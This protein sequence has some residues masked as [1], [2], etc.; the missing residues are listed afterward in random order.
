MVEQWKEFTPFNGTL[1]AFK[2]YEKDL[3]SYAS[4][5]TDDS[6]SNLAQT[7]EDTDMG[8]AGPGAAPMP[9]PAAPVGGGGIAAAL[10]LDL[11]KMQ[12]LRT[13]RLAAAYQLLYKSNAD[14]DLKSELHST[15]RLPAFPSGALTM[16]RAR[17]D[18]TP[19]AA[20]MTE[21]DLHWEG[22]T[23]AKDVGFAAD[24]VT[25][26]ASLLDRENADRPA[27]ARKDPTQKTERLLQ[28]IA[29]ASAHFHLSAQA[30]I[31][32]PVGSRTYELAVP[33]ALPVA[34]VPAGWLNAAGQLIPAALPAG[35]VPAPNPRHRDFAACVADF[36]RQWREAFRS[37]IITPAAATRRNP[38]APARHTVDARQLDDEGN[39]GVE[40]GMSGSELVPVNT[41]ATLGT[42]RSIGACRRGCVTTTDFGRIGSELLCEAADNDNVGRGFSLVTVYDATDTASM[43]M[44]CHRCWGA[45]HLERDCPSAKKHRSINYMLGLLTARKDRAE[46]R[47]AAAGR[48]A[49]GIAA[50]Q[51]RGQ[52]APFRTRPRSEQPRATDSTRRPPPHRATRGGT[53]SG[54]RQT[55]REAQDDS[56]DDADA[57]ADYSDDE[58][59]ADEGGG[60]ATEQPL[61]FDE[62]EY[63]EEG[64]CVEE[65]TLTT[66]E[67]L[68]E[69]PADMP[70]LS[71]GDEV[72]MIKAEHDVKL[73]EYAAKL[74]AVTQELHRV[75][76]EKNDQQP[77][78]N[79]PLSLAPLLF[80]LLAMVLSGVIAYT[81]T[82]SEVMSS[83]A[84]SCAAWLS[85]KL[86]TAADAMPAF[87]LRLLLTANVGVLIVTMLLLCG[88]RP[89]RAG[90]EYLLDTLNGTTYEYAREGSEYTPSLLSG[91]TLRPNISE[92]QFLNNN[93]GVRWCDDSGATSCCKPPSPQSPHALF[94][95]TEEHPNIKLVVASGSRL[96]VLRVGKMHATVK[97]FVKLPVGTRKCVREIITLSRVLEVEG[98]ATH[99]LSVSSIKDLDGILSYFN[100]DNS[101][102]E[103]QCLALGTTGT[104][105]VI[106]PFTAGAKRNEVLLS[107]T[108]V[109]DLTACAA[110]EEPDLS[111]LH[112]SL[113]HI[114]AHKMRV[115][116]ITVNKTLLSK[117][118]H[119]QGFKHDPATCPGCRLGGALQ[120]PFRHAKAPSSKSFVPSSSDSNGVPTQSPGRA[121]AFG[122]CVHSDVS[123][124]FP[125]SW[126]HGFTGYTNFVDDCT[127]EYD[128]Y[129][130]VNLTAEEVSGCLRE[131]S[132]ANRTRL[133]DGLI[134]VWKCDNATVYT[135]DETEDAARELVSRREYRVPNQANTSG[136]P[137]RAIGII[138]R[139]ARTMVAHAGA[140]QCLWPWAASQAKW[141]LYYLPSRSLGGKSPFEAQHPDA[142]PADLSW[143]R[144]MFCDVSITYAEKDVDGKMGYT[145]ADGCHLGYDHLRKCHYVYLPEKRRLGSFIVKKWRPKDFTIC[146]SIIADTPVEY[147]QSTDLNAAP[148]TASLLPRHFHKDRPEMN[149]PREPRRE[150]RTP[151]NDAGTGPA[152]APVALA[153]APRQQRA[154]PPPPLVPPRAPPIETRGGGGGSDS[155]GGSSGSDDG[156]PAAQPAAAPPPRSQGDLRVTLRPAPTRAPNPNDLSRF[157][158]RNSSA[159]SAS[160]Q[161]KEGV[162]PPSTQKKEGAVS[163]PQASSCAAVAEAAQAAFEQAMNAT[164]ER[165]SKLP[166]ADSEAVLAAIAQQ[167]ATW[168]ANKLWQHCLALGAYDELYPAAEITILADVDGYALRVSEVGGIPVPRSLA[169]AR[170]LKQWP[171]FKA[172]MEE[173][174]KGKFKDNV[175]W[176]VVKRPTGKHVM[177]SRWVYTVQYL[178]DGSIKKIKA[179]FVAK[180]FSQTADEFDKIKAATLPGVSFRTFFALLIAQDWESDHI[181][182]VKAFT[183]A[184]IDKELYCE[185]PEGFGKPGCVLKLRKAL[186]G[187]RQGAYLWQQLNVKALRECGLKNSL[188]EPNIFVHPTLP[189]RIGV[190][191]DDV[192]GAF[193]M[194]AIDE[195]RA[196]RLKY[197]KIIKIDS[198]DITPITKFTGVEITRDR[199][200]KTG[201]ISQE[202]YI[203]QLAVLYKGQFTVHSTPTRD[204]KAA[205]DMFEKLKPAEEGDELVDQT[206]YL[207]L[208]GAMLWPATMTQ[209]HMSVYC[210]YLAS[211]MMAPTTAH[212]NAALWLLGYLVACKRM[213]ITYGGKLKTPHGV[214]DDE[215]PK[216]FFDSYGL[217]CY[218]DSSWGKSPKPM[219]GFILM[220][221][222]GAIDWSAKQLKV[223]ADSTCEAETAS[224]S[225]ATKAIRFIRGLI[226]FMLGIALA[227]TMLLVDNS[228]LTSLVANE[229]ATVRTRYF[230]R[231]TMLVK[232]ATVRLQIDLRL[233]PTAD[234]VADIMTKATDTATLFK[235]RGYAMN[236]AGAVQDKAA[237]AYA[238]AHKMLQKLN[239][240][241]ESYRS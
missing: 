191:A 228:A 119:V 195:Y 146:K 226:V 56:N 69:M 80:G 136:K 98:L 17:F 223:V 199:D 1:A 14:M 50:R 61:V 204:S 208:M 91:V 22:L 99:L 6:G 89:A 114:G 166:E 29:A 186:E 196:L 169:E 157:G 7:L 181:D 235:M 128:L 152:R 44:L 121:T 83:A 143:A 102:G 38:G 58:S 97:G 158:Q 194:K 171:L 230:E 184:D 39:A 153:P 239:S 84:T 232:E 78:L 124:P 214:D 212:M 63:F 127:S 49:G 210:S 180:G 130:I 79:A 183:Q 237:V 10:Q 179:R 198:H 115:A 101:L 35:V 240:I 140:Q 155:D 173:E 43:E 185:M 122:Q 161:K 26:A 217:H 203:E 236:L 82:A 187:I 13:A 77:V 108:V 59:M 170:K 231:A 33:A 62:T 167:T 224:A 134:G 215:L 219:A 178:K 142:P 207:S 205:R 172:A 131:Y 106:V 225:R 2:Q 156:S 41:T 175:A 81:S 190:F 96:K 139:M 11:T 24:T 221:L 241:V 31:N 12:R 47:A 174:I 88:V 8:G 111:Q 20:E 201:T 42:L 4:G 74:E 70:E 25:S 159:L 144:P 87:S 23:I 30:E 75:T 149:Q 118:K 45:G 107:P 86:A 141:L 27:N 90:G 238:K 168:D 229:G 209:P 135:A 37:R 154:A 218:S 15:Y 193:D 55:A 94:E 48:G 57:A 147:H 3:L 125:R 116:N 32:R 123:H 67:Q 138:D 117:S 150:R 137:E 34:G 100:T 162:T 46:A 234:E 72:A 113:G 216:G 220:L 148:P 104:D 60:V 95:V 165:A 19:S 92:V 28:M 71:L 192:F 112:V 73:S 133:R 5:I 21:K 177:K 16:L 163:T 52:R 110:D 233:V 132:F 53:I 129:F 151:R 120:P 103:E 93:N 160:A 85:T 18:R 145:G 9:V 54:S 36:D 182:A 176:D 65:I 200:A 109:S 126:P 164:I 51:P 76:K 188:A 189:I 40:T 213:G 105:R 222:N 202:Q 211:F 68:A 197:S 227:P 66:A 206:A 64:D